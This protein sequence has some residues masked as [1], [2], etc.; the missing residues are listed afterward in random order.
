M[1]AQKGRDVLIKVS[2]AGTYTTIGGM[3]QKQIQVQEDTVDV[4]DS[5]SVGRWRELLAGAGFLS[6]SI[7][8]SGVFK[9][10]SAEGYLLTQKLA[11]VIPSFQFIVPGLGT[12]QGP[13]QIG[14]LQYAGAAN[15]EVNFSA[16]FESAGEVTFTAQ[17]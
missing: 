2:I 11:G 13:F 12:F 4:S 1:A 9:D 7:S 6:M 15:G 10:S 14:S 8:G 16:S 5:D 17:N 3:R